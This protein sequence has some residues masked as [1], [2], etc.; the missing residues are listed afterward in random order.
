M[1]SAS[2]PRHVHVSDLVNKNLPH[3][4]N[5]CPTFGEKRTK[6][7][8][9]MLIHPD[10][11]QDMDAFEEF[12]QCGIC[13]SGIHTHC[14]TC[15]KPPNGYTGCRLCKP[16]GLVEKTCPVELVDI[17]Q[18]GQNWSMGKCKLNT[19][20]AMNLTFTKVQM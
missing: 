3:Y 4:Y 2:L 11:L 5:A 8:R 20:S 12:Y 15:R 10:P 9:A 14:M 19:K 1:Y 17:T 18:S 16:S 13:R 6:A 7:G